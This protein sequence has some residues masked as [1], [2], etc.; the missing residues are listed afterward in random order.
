MTDEELEAAMLVPLVPAEAI[1]GVA[2]ATSALEQAEQ[3]RNEA[4]A[5]LAIAQSTEADL[6]ESLSAVDSRIETLRQALADGRMTA[7]QA[8]GMAYLAAL[9]HDQLD[10][11]LEQAAM[12]TAMCLEALQDAETACATAAADLSRA[13]TGVE[14]AAQTARVSV[15]E[16]ELVRAVGALHAIGRRLGSPHLSQNWRVSL[17]LLRHLRSISC[18]GGIQLGVPP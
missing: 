15:L 6:R 17:P 14:F 16:A 11:Q 18:A 9:D 5:A 3:Q 1:P 2:D 12:T 4:L 13:Q 8:G 7:E 10:A